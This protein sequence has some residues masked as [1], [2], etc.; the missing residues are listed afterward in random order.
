MPWQQGCCL[1]WN[2]K[3]HRDGERDEAK[4]QAERDHWSPINSKALKRFSFRERGFSRSLW[5]VWSF[6]NYVEPNYAKYSRR[7]TL[8]NWGRGKA[9]AII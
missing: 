2:I 7:Q 4:D 8:K 3:P 1:A 6:L 9:N 5:L